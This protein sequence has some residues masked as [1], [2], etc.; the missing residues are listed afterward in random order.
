MHVT[1]TCSHNTPGCSIIPLALNQLRVP[2]HLHW[3][4]QLESFHITCMLHKLSNH[5][6]DL[7]SQL[8]PTC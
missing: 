6:Q 7:L 4:F 1:V 8:D 5:G 2:H 3:I